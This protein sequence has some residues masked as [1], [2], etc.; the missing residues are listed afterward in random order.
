MR[1]QWDETYLAQ[2][3]TQRFIPR[4]SYLLPSIPSGA[5]DFLQKL[6][7]CPALKDKI[8]A[9]LM[10]RFQEQAKRPSASVVPP[11]KAQANS[12]AGEISPT[13][14]DTFCEGK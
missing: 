5:A 14:A 13:K 3:I 12:G 9:D 11:A 2:A 8:P 10:D 1:G 7:S 4:Q 6:S